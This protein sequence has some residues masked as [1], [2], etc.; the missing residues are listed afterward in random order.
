MSTIRIGRWRPVPAGDG[1]AVALDGDRIAVA[2]QAYLEVWQGRRLLATAEAPWPAPGRPRF[3]GSEVRWGPGTLDLSSGAYRAMAAA[4]PDRWPGGGERPSVHSWSPDGERLLVGYA[5]G[6]PEAGARVDLFD[7]TSGELIS[8]LCSG[9]AL[10]PLA[11]WVGDEVAVVGFE[12]LVAYDVSDGRSLGAVALGA[13]TIAALDS[14]HSETCLVAVDLNQ[15]LFWV[16]ARSR[17]LVDRWD[18]R[19]L[20]AGVSPDG[21][22]VAAVDVSGGVRFAGLM[23][24][25]IRPCGGVEGVGRVTAICLDDHHVAVAGGGSVAIATYANE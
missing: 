7:G 19:W 9:H 25:R 23:D 4:E 20:A 2:S 3:V 6:R 11:A 16:D 13:S 22:L 1:T 24:G 17:E 5:T 12:D 15:A 21:G 10:P 8:T 14:D 18:G